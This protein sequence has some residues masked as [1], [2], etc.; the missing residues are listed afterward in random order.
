MA[1][2]SEDWQ[3]S[4]WKSM[5]ISR[6]SY[7]KLNIEFRMNSRL[8]RSVLV[9]TVF[10]CQNILWDIADHVTNSRYFF[11]FLS[12]P[13]DFDEC[14]F[15][16]S[17]NDS[18]WYLRAQDPG[19]RQQWVDAIEQ[20][21]V[22]F[23]SDFLSHSL[24]LVVVVESCKLHCTVIKYSKYIWQLKAVRLKQCDKYVLKELI[25]LSFIAKIVEN[26]ELKNVN[27]SWVL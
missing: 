13:H 25:Y 10:E 19:H 24:D 26:W 18:V 8:Y 12:Q 4:L 9:I 15:D 21:K 23:F 11:T 7:L 2:G 17:V 6:D 1:S 3:F 5:L 20:H 16:I 27:L 22:C 14:R